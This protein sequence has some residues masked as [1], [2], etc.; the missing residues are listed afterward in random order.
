MKRALLIAEKPSAA[1]A[2]EEA[3]K[4]MPQG[5]EYDIDFTSAAGHLVALFEPN[6]Y[7]E[8][9]G[10]P[11]KKEVLPIVPKEWKTKVVN[12]KFYNNIKEM[13]EKGGYDVVINAGDAG[14]EGQL[15]QELMKA[16]INE[17]RLKKG[18][19]VKGDGNRVFGC[20]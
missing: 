10:M 5:Y 17:A 4:K 15:I 20:I 3:Y 16:R 19:E 14:R 12:A 13:W 7:D 18:Y 1:K 2:I 8:A 6:E 11:W 9:W